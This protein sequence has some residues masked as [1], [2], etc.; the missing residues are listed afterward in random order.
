MKIATTLALS[1]AT[2]MLAPPAAEG[3]CPDPDVDSTI[4]LELGA[5]ALLPVGPNPALGQTLVASGNQVTAIDTKGFTSL[6]FSTMTGTVSNTP[7]PVEMGD[8]SGIYAAFIAQQ[9]A[10]VTRIDAQSM[11][12]QWS[13][14]LDSGTACGSDAITATA[15]IH[16]RRFATD[17]FKATFPHDLVYVAT[18]YGCGNTTDNKVF[19]LDAESGDPVWI[20]NSGGT[21]DM[22]AVL[23]DPFLDIEHDRLYVATDRTDPTQDSLFAIDTLTGNKAWSVNVGRLWTSPV[24]RGDRIYVVTLFGELK[25]LSAADGTVIW[26]VANPTGQPVTRNLF[27]EFR[28]PYGGLMVAVDFAGGLWMVRDDGAAGITQ[29][30]VT[31]PAP[32]SSRVAVDPTTGKIYVGADDGQI[33]QLNLVDGAVES[34][35]PVGAKMGAI[36]VPTLVFGSINPNGDL[37]MMAGTANGALGKLCLPWTAE[38]ADAFAP[39]PGPVA[40]APGLCSAASDCGAQATQCAEW[41]CV[42]N[43]CVTEP[44]PDGKTCD[45]GNTKTPKDFC[46]SGTCAGQSD[47]D[48]NLDSCSCTDATGQTFTRT[49]LAEQPT[50]PPPPTGSM[51]PKGDWCATEVSRVAADNLCLAHNTNARSVVTVTLMDQDSRPFTKAD[52]KMTIDTGDGGAANAPVW[53]DP[54]TDTPLQGTTVDITNGVSHGVVESARPGTYFAILGGQKGRSA[55]RAPYPII[56]TA[57]KEVGGVICIDPRTEQLLP[58]SVVAGD[59]NDV[60]TLDSDTDRAG[61]LRI[62][63][64]DSIASNQPQAGAVV[65]VGH[66]VDNTFFFGIENRLIAKAYETF[67]KSPLAPD[68]PN[69]AKTDS[70]GIVEF[71]DFGNEMNGPFEVL[72]NGK[73]ACVTEA[74]AVIPLNI[75]P[76]PCQQL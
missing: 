50:C 48:L 26:S 41:A 25:A 14:P 71:F 65:T 18:R 66:T 21:F 49:L 31:L 15:A 9:D 59:A 58:V 38:R 61:Y 28:A 40:T 60:C 46:K 63:V 10:L 27:T 7:N 32:A 55:G 1:A 8:G 30:N 69:T 75:L 17:N 11:A 2:F 3:N 54:A 74:D 53:I 16:L 70:N 42:D 36:G 20:F 19:A 44:V 34:S 22:D 45:D 51:V 5:T 12:I 73:E 6:G 13:T 64:V 29:W 57:R 68:Q 37:L 72:V 24:V 56:V 52:V 76:L 33:Y 62:K 43:V 23:S 39:E 4:T 67:L 47:C 35:R